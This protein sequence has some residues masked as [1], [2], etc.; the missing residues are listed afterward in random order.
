MSCEVHAG[1]AGHGG[2]IH[3]ATHLVILTSRKTE[4]IME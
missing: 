1:S 3:R 4:E 2:E